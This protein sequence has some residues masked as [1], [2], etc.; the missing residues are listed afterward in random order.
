M[1]NV[2]FFKTYRSLGSKIYRLRF[3]FIRLTDVDLFVVFLVGSVL[4]AFVDRTGITDKAMPLVGLHYDPWL[5][6]GGGIISA[7][8]L[9]LINKLRPD[10]SIDIFMR[11][12]FAPRLYAPR[13]RQGDRFWKPSDERLSVKSIKSR[14]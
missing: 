7:L 13:S 11:G 6:T 5:W 8:V 9:S 12:I 3:F 14:Y 4:W 1:I 10:D 2:P